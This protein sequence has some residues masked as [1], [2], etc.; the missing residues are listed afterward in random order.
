MC[1][2][3][4]TAKS[5]MDRIIESMDRLAA[6]LCEKTQPVTV[7]VFNAPLGTTVKE[8]S[9]ASGRRIDISFPEMVAR[10]PRG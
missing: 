3:K 1:A 7:N 6:A 5:K 8:T 9:D 4:Q 10:S 2:N